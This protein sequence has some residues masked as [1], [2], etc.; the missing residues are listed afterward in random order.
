MIRFF[1][2]G[3]GEFDRHRAAGPVRW[4][5][6]DL[7]WLHTGRMRMR[8]MSR[9][10]VVLTANSGILI[11][12]DTSFVGWAM[13]DLAKASVQHF[14][15]EPDDGQHLPAPM[16]RLLGRRR[17]YERYH[18]AHHET[19]DA[20][21]RRA[22]ELSL[23]K[24]TPLVHDL[25][26]ASLTLILGTLAAHVRGRGQVPIAPATRWDALL[27]WLPAQL[28]RRVSVEEMAGQLGWS[29]SHFAARF[30][31]TFGLSPAQYVQKARILEAARMLREGQESIKGVAR[32]LGFEDLPNFYRSFSA[33]T[34]F[35][36]ARYRERYRLRA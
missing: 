18:L 34:A 11:Y 26:V 17:G 16:A 3:Y 8:L 30:R 4:D 32:Q 7:F 24:Q 20:D 12:P 10:D 28:G 13:S 27:A 29:A 6:F 22:I 1:D 2:H 23:Q 21:V 19:F 33:V 15:L 35:T 5:R 31:Q 9:A 14:A 36:P 25:R